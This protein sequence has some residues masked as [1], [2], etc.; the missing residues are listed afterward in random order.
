[1]MLSQPLKEIEGNNLS[2]S[3]FVANGNPFFFA[4]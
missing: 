1:M 2:I 3:L 4:R